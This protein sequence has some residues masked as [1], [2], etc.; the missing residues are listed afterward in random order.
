MLE[1]KENRERKISDS[2]YFVRVLLKIAADALLLWKDL[3][4]P[5]STHWLVSNFLPQAYGLIIT[6]NE[7][8]LSLHVIYTCVHGGYCQYVFSLC[9]KDAEEPK[10][11]TLTSQR[12]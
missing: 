6:K 11:P 12:N 3:G 10:Y 8:I 1:L 7:W 2:L 4:M 5:T 9:M